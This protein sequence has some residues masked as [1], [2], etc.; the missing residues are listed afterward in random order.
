MPLRASIPSRKKKTTE[1][2]RF[3]G[4][5]Q[6]ARGHTAIPGLIYMYEP[7]YL[8][9]IVFKYSSLVLGIEIRDS[10]GSRTVNHFYRKPIRWLKILVYH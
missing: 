3:K 4:T 2:L 6:Q 5:S 8:K 7:M 1:I 9:G 10:M